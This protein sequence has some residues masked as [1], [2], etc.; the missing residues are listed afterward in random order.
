MVVKK[1]VK[2]GSKDLYIKE[3]YYFLKMVSFKELVERIK[4]Y[5][6]FSKQEVSGLVVAIIVTGF[7]FSFRDW[8]VEEFNLIFGLKNFLLAIIVAAISFWFK[9]SCQKVYGLGEGQDAEFKTWWVGIVV[10]LVLGF[11]TSGWVPLILAGGVVSS[12]MVRQR[13]GEFRYGFSTWT[14]AI[15]AMWAILGNLILAIIFSI[16]LHFFPQSYFLDVGMKM[17]LMMAFCSWLPFPQ[18]DGLALFFGSRGLFFLGIGATL[19]AAVLLLT[20]TTIGLIVAIVIGTL[21]SI[22]YM[23]VGSEK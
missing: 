6:R 11:I 5:Y 13:L 1:V 4:D 19:L 20:K 14:M 15:T 9:I 18:Q 8:G 21:I 23:M 2:K 22:G 16:G 10:M 3:I 12:F 17:N 7:L